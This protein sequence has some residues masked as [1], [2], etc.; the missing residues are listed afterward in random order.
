M[1]SLWGCSMNQ[2]IE[3][4]IFDTNFNRIGIIE[5]YI[6]ITN[7]KNYTNHSELSFEL[8]GNANYVNLLNSDEIRIITL[9]T[10]INRGYIVELVEYIDAQQTHVSVECRSLSVMLDWRIILGQMR[11]AG[12]IEDVM[13]AFVTNNAISPKNTN[14]IIPNLAIGADYGINTTTEATYSDCNLADALWEIA[15]SH[16]ISYEI[17]MNH[18]NK[19]Y[20]FSVFTGTDRSATQNVNPHII[21]SKTFDNIELQSFTEAKADFKNCAVIRGSDG[22]SMV[23]DANVGFDRRELIVDASNVKRVYKDDND[24]EIT[25]TQQQYK[26]SLN[27]LG[28]GNLAQ[29]NVVRSFETDISINSQNVYNRDFTL[30]DI[31]TSRN[32]ELG[33]IVHANIVRSIETWDSSGYKLTLELGS[34]IPTLIEKL[35]RSGN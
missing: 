12:K 18:T 7:T 28:A 8:D 3:L 31:V 2:T 27:E 24:T 20:V 13:Q 23:G 30:G 29:R 6:T 32:D 4:Y 10:D 34:A 11:F 25:L 15:N 9:S 16:N 26:N 22:D 1:K 5:E 14:R 35:K 19:R 21:F 33:V 17:L